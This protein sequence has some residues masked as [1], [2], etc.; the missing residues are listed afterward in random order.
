MRPP[1][2]LQDSADR[3]S[4]LEN[5]PAR[6]RNADSSRRRFA[7]CCRKNSCVNEGAEMKCLVLAAGMSTRLAALNGGLPKPLTS[8]AGVPVL[9]RNLQWLAK[10]GITETFVNL[11]Y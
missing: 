6:K 2:G 7:R 5:P 10:H 11:H 1:R 3:Q 8:V 4:A 9:R